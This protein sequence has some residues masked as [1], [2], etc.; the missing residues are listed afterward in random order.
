[1]VLDTMDKLVDKL[2][3][4]LVDMVVDMRTGVQALSVA[5]RSS[6]LQLAK[7]PVIL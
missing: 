7:K 2:A 6:W 4:K 3:D 1:M 5:R